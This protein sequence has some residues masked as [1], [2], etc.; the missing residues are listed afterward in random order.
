M[1]QLMEPLLTPTE[2]AALLGMSKG[3]LEVWR[4]TKRYPLDF[5]K[6]GGRVRYRLSDVQKFIE[7]RVNRCGPE[8]TTKVR[9]KRCS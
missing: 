5:I 9:R 1:P 6:I 3:T 4:C 2:T 7:S 8:A